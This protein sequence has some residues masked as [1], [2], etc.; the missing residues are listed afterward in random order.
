ML[1][2]PYRLP[3]FEVSRIMKSGKRIVHSGITLIYRPASVSRFAFVVSR[4]VDKR[5]TTRNRMRRLMSESVRHLMPA[6]ARPINGIFIGSKF[7]IGKTQK[8]VQGMVQEVLREA[9]SS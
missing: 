4:K 5:A 3:A 2:K 9:I 6:I 8:E 1:S 7:L